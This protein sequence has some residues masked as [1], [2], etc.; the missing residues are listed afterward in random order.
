MIG[1]NLRRGHR[2]FG[3]TPKAYYQS[4]PYLNY[5]D[6]NEKSFLEQKYL[7]MIPLFR[8]QRAELLKTCDHKDVRQY[9]EEQAEG[10][11]E[12]KEFAMAGRSNVGKSS[13]INAI[14]SGKG[15]HYGST[16][17]TRKS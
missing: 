10:Q 15:R 2:L 5:M 3:S 12:V 9:L 11:A 14:L 17:A 1:V 6:A 4:Q 16:A 8:D 13:L 7:D